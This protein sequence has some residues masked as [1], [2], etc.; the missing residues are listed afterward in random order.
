MRLLSRLGAA[1]LG[2]FLIFL[3]LPLLLDAW[4]HRLTD[5]GDGATTGAA[6]AALHGE[7]VIADLH[8]DSLLWP[9]D[10]LTRHTRG[11]VDVPRLTDGNVALQVFSVVTSVPAGRGPRRDREGLDLIGPLAAAQGWPW[12][13]WTSSFER[14]LYQASRLDRAAVDS[15]ARL[16]RIRQRSDLSRLE[17]A[18]DEARVRGLL[19]PI[20]AV[21]SLEGAGMVAGR[22]DRLEHLFAAGFRIDGLVH[23]ADNDLGGSSQGRSGQGLSGPGREVLSTMRQLGMIPDLAHASPALIREVLATSPGPV[24]VSHTGLAALCPGARNLDDDLV[25]EIA[26]AGGLIGIGFWPEAVCGGTIADIA[27]TVRHAI[28]VAGIDHVALGSDFDGSVTA[29]FDASGLERLTEALLAS[30]LSRE[31]LAQVMGNNVLRFLRFALP[32]G[33]SL[34]D[35]GKELPPRQSPRGLQ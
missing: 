22:P 14:A 9:R 10:P 34:A 26:A 25:R 15:G 16:L 12:R 32:A 21:L 2:A 35:E 20:G 24:L 6:A 17:L 5:T 29:P 30:G 11:Q 28:A 1:L 27:A 4:F 7:L 31:A 33:A 18:R 8:A 19:P 3:S 23:L 13:T